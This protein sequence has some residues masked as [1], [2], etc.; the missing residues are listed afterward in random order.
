MPPVEF[1]KISSKGQVVIPQSI[2]ERLGI[3]EGMPFAVWSDG[4]EILLKKMEIPEKKSW[5]EIAAPFRKISKENKITEDDVLSAIKKA[6]A[7]K[8]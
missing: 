3:T 5:N 2:R 7:R 4:D 8:G 1:T 6:R